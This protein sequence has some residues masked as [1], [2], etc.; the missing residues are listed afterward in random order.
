MI[1]NGNH[2]DAVDV[3]NR[4]MNSDSQ[5]KLPE[6][7]NYEILCEL[8][9][10]GM[11]VVYKAVHLALKRVVAIKMIRTSGKVTAEDLARFRIE[12][13]AIARLQHP[14]IVQIHDIGEHAGIPHFALEYMPGGTLDR[15][16]S[17]QPIA[18][19]QAA[20]L[21]EVL[22]RAI[23][24]AHEIG[25]VHRDLKPG[26]ILL[27]KE[28][29]RAVASASNE[30]STSNSTQIFVGTMKISDFG[31]A[32]FF[33][34]KD[35]G[36]TESGSILGTP[37]Y[38]AP[39]QAKGQT[40]GP[41]VD[42]YALGA[43]L[44]ELITGRPPFRAA[45]AWDTIQ[46][47]VTDD[48]VPPRRMQSKLPSDL[49][50]ICM[51]CLQKL[52]RQRYGSALALAEDLRHFLDDEP[53][54]ARPIGSSERILKWAKRRPSRAALIAVCFLGS[55][56]LLAS[57]FKYSMDLSEANTQIRK[58]R[59]HAVQA[60]E[61]TKN[62]WNRARRSLYA[63]QLA[64]VSTVYETDP[65]RG[66][67]LLEDRERCPEELRDFSWSLFQQICK[68]SHRMLTGHTKTVRSAIYS[69][70]GSWLASAS[71]D[72]TIKVWDLANC[73]ERFTVT[74][75]HG[76]VRTLAIVD[77][78]KTLL[79]GMEDGVLQSFSA[80][81]GH[82]TVTLKGHTKGVTA[83]VA[84]ADGSKI[85]SASSDGEILLHRGLHDKQPITLGVAQGLTSMAFAPNGKH[86]ATSA[87]NGIVIWDIESR[88]PD[89]G[90]PLK[91]KF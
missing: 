87:A 41:P 37:S 46:Q 23:H 78:D 80:A 44:Y 60:E 43:I 33:D 75:N 20:E 82:P 91:Q 13:E 39:E 29:I 58:E 31:L 45:T 48:P 2:P 42:I 21:I 5:T 17:G 89:T 26:N 67:T 15:R 79:A 70:D 85:A 56:I 90:P 6:L 30:F 69:K 49:N 28:E 34:S 24:Y 61:A 86:I 25:I 11:G 12:A 8:G 66:L 62:E 55:L 81:D 76:A 4:T 73:K 32:K 50:T 63:L 7:P 51:K 19:R 22:A 72:G 74:G 65:A 27:E 83:L 71:Y 3:H 16:L 68:R 9:S 54:M 57:W 10:G 36:Q 1:A 84:T 40:I 52:P 77:G 64:N 59:D 88:R 38:M 18:F 53:I 14:N 47:V 35:V